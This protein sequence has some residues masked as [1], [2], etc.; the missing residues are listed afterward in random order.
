MAFEATVRPLDGVKGTVFDACSMM[1]HI[2]E[3]LK[4]LAVGCGFSMRVGR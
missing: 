4:F 3:L 2:V 1:V